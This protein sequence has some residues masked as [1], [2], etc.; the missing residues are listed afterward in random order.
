MVLLELNQ[1]PG[2]FICGAGSTL[3]IFKF[4]SV[5]GTLE[6]ISE[7]VSSFHFIISLDSC[8]DKIAVGDVIDSLQLFKFTKK[9]PENN[10]P[11][12]FKIERI[13]K[14]LDCK[15]ASV[16]LFIDKNTILVADDKGNL[17]AFSAK[18]KNYTNDSIFRKDML[19]LSGF[20]I[21]ERV[22]MMKL[23]SLVRFSMHSIDS[24]YQQLPI[25]QSVMYVTN[26][27]SIGI[28]LMSEK[29]STIQFLKNIE[30]ALDKTLDPIG[31]IS[32]IEYRNSWKKHNISTGLMRKSNEQVTGFIDIDY[33]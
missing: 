5:K 10:T 26:I 27:G 30:I 3:A 8:E 13:G 32:R 20:K 16:V 7:K 15:S 33:L 23:G 21:G 28:L 31:G 11:L 19:P 29:E 24:E 6:C 9:N 2:C 12:S 4:N 22:T 18:E 14:S 17:I 1:Y 25:S